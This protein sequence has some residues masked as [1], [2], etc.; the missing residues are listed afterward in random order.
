M[1]ATQA[2]TGPNHQ[3]RNAPEKGSSSFSGA[4]ADQQH[5]F[6]NCSSELESV[7][8]SYIQFRECPIKRKNTEFGE[9]VLVLNPG[10]KLTGGGSRMGKVQQPMSPG[11][12][13]SARQRKRT[14]T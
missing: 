6:D 1:R 13:G 7:I 5:D 3:N 12:C 9:T 10:E 14:N 2:R 4:S 8:Q 11:G